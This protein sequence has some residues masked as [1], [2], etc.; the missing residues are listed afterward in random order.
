MYDFCFFFLEKLE[1]KC[2]N[3]YFKNYIF[4][5]VRSPLKSTLNALKM[6]YD[7]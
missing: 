5:L 2:W 7:T 1:K 6:F 3:D 4:Q